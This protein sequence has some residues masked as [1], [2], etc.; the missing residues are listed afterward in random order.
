[1]QCW[2]CSLF[3][4]YTT[5]KLTRNKNYSNATR[6]PWLVPN[7]PQQHILSVNSYKWYYVCIL[8]LLWPNFE[9]LFLTILLLFQQKCYSFFYGRE[10][11]KKNLCLCS[12]IQR[13][14]P[15]LPLDMT[16]QNKLKEAVIA[17]SHLFCVQIIA[18]KVG[19]VLI[20][21]VVG[22]ISCWKAP[23]IQIH[24]RYKFTTGLL[25]GHNINVSSH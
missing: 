22:K 11:E 5:C 4:D 13:G 3:T 1:M 23:M 24:L 17:V 2:L 18:L 21:P 15:W 25:C 8:F 7:I 9:F 16:R 14:Q 10:S 20:F 12:W 6:M 19:W